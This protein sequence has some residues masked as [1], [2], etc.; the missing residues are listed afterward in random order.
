LSGKEFVG[1]K[2][3]CEFHDRL[4]LVMLS[5]AETSGHRPGMHLIRG[6]IPP[7]RFAPVGMTKSG[8]A[9]R[10]D[11]PVTLNRLPS[12]VVIEGLVDGCGGGA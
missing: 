8:A 11:L 2:L 12:R 10:E 6:E 3:A 7:L 9:L 4:T 1:R 5:E